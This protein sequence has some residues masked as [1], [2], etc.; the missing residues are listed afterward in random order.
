MPNKVT[1]TID[2]Q[3]KLKPVLDQA[4]NQLGSFE[5]TVG[6]VGTA[7]KGLAVGYLVKQLVDF[8]GSTLDV[9]DN[10]NKMAQRTGVSVE[11]LSGL[12]HAAQLA[13]VDSQSF[14][15]SLK[16]LAVTI[17]DAH[18]GMKE[19]KDNLAALG[20]SATDAQ[21]KVRSTSDV[22]G[23]IADKFQQTK[24]GADKAA[25]ATKVFGKAGTEMIP[26]LNQGSAGLKA[27]QEEAKRLGIVLSQEDAQAAEDFHDNI[28]RL[29]EAARGLMQNF[30][31]GLLPALNQTFAAM[32]GSGDD[33]FAG[34]KTA[35]E[36][37]G[38]IV[39][40]L[41]LGFESLAIGIDYAAHKL[42]LFV[43]ATLA[44]ASF[45]AKGF[46]EKFGMLVGSSTDA[47]GDK[48]REQLGKFEQSLFDPQG[49]G[50]SK[51][52]GT[53]DDDLKRRNDEAE[54]LQKARWKADIEAAR[55]AALV[56]KQLADEDMQRL[57]TLRAHDLISVKDYTTSASRWRSRSRSLRSQSSRRRSRSR[58]R[59]AT[60]RPMRKTRSPRRRSLTSCSTSRSR[61]SAS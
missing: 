26:L 50:A 31:S 54:A 38:T 17:S 57:D 9:A 58:R 16:K 1:V 53:G 33:A 4:G 45:D 41:V 40:Y 22:L 32:S 25:L 10:L 11:E 27:M 12:Q 15:K 8:A 19:A 55:E 49:K 51:G 30:L 35:G 7:L 2:G 44:L 18:A 47:Q 3:N 34:A 60:R 20:I 13:D 39:K 36:A 6:K 29:Q 21:G 14:E 5:S 52:S 56:H 28:T 42:G 24:D 61:K 59:C 23:Q 46:A 37:L 43:D 48:L